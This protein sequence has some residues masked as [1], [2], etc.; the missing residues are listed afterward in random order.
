MMPLASSPPDYEF[1]S[2]TAQFVSTSSSVAHDV[3]VEPLYYFF[4]VAVFLLVMGFAGAFL[5]RRV[6]IDDTEVVLHGKKTIDLSSAPQFEG[7][8]AL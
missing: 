5:Q 1:A 2:T 6:P 7:I 4:C 3:K 8:E